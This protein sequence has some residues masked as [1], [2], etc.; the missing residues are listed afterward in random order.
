MDEAV[1]RARRLRAEAVRAWARLLSGWLRMHV[2]E[3]VRRAHQRRR[4]LDVLMTLDERTL[5]DIG[6]QRSQIK[7]LVY[8]GAPLPRPA[9]QPAIG[10]SPSVTRLP[11]A[12]PVPGAIARGPED[13]S[14]A[15]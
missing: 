7:A 14:R 3:P 2:V 12:E 11:T 1:A 15:A 10:A 6:V 4:D 13:L 9:P 8:S 5:A